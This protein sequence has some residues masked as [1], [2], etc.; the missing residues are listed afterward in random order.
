VDEHVKLHQGHVWVEDRPDGEKGAC[1][2]IE[3]PVVEV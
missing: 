3:L 2:I 1:F